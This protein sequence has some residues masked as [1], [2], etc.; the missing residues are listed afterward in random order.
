VFDEIYGAFTITEDHQLCLCL[1]LLKRLADEA[2]IR[3]VIF[4]EQNNVA[5]I[6]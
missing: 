6:F 1:M 3:R 5:S 4:D 2:G